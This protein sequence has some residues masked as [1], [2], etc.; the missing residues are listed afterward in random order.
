MAPR[1]WRSFDSSC[2]ERR[3]KLRKFSHECYNLSSLFWI[4]NSGLQVSTC[5]DCNSFFFYKFNSNICL[6]N[7]YISGI[8]VVSCRVIIV[9]KVISLYPV[10][11]P[12]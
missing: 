8:R 3:G 12:L 2:C 11:D 7:L 1:L 9:D 4:R 6:P 10:Q 5:M